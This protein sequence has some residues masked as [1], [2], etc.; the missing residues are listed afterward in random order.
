MLVASHSYSSSPNSN[1]IQTSESPVKPTSLKERVSK[2]KAN[3][4]IIEIFNSTLFDTEPKEKKD[5]SFMWFHDPELKEKRTEIID[6]KLSSFEAW[7]KIDLEAFLLD[8]QFNYTEVVRTKVNTKII[9]QIMDSFFIQAEFELLT[10]SGSIQKVF[11]RAGETSGI[12]QREILLLWQATDWLTIQGGAVNQDFLE[13]PLLLG[14]IAFPSIV[15]N[16]ELFKGEEHNLSLS[17][18]Q[19]IPTSFAGDNSIYTQDL[20]KTPL[21]ITKSF[22]WKYN[23][24]SFYKVNLNSSFFHYN[25]LPSDIAR[26][27]NFYGNTVSEE[28]PS[29][30]YRY[31]GF[32]FILEPSFQISSKL[33][34]KLKLHYINNIRKIEEENLNQGV[35][36][37]LQVP[38]DLTENVRVTS[39]FEYFKT[40]PD[41]SVGYYNSA[42]YGHSNR[43]GFIGEIV[44]HFYNRN[45]EV[46]FR[47][48]R[49]D[50]LK[51]SDDDN[52]DDDIG[53]QI[54]YLLFLRTNY[55]KLY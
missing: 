35:L 49:S 41:A 51:P 19:A 47:H 32:Y 7:W 42:K 15:E 31:T 46:G 16:I 54:Y 9:T 22:F 27:S 3:P 43:E 25:P 50:D 6:S 1:E 29:F 34:L 21:L 39:S 14:D 40:Q 12:S 13:S 24:E 53:N 37:G 11:Q 20:T 23:P 52:D 38:F 45:I 36:Y 18:Q 48:M 33:G 26:E 10:G 28:P 4:Q 5:T 2:Q 8:D 17:F 30:R 55:A 44:F